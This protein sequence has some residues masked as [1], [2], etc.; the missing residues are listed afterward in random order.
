[1]QCVS[2][3]VNQNHLQLYY[4]KILIILKE[5]LTKTISNKYTAYICPVPNIKTIYNMK[6]VDDIVLIGHNSFVFDTPRLLRKEGREFSNQLQEMKVLFTD[7]L[8]IIKF[9]RSQP[10]NVL[11]SSPNNK[12][13]SVYKALFNC[14][15][16]AHDALV[17]VKALARIQFSLPL[18]AS[19]EI[20]VSRGKHLY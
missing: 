4:N 15:F 19:S 18:E 1:M 6:P 14:E 3:R 5:F 11:K 9:I 16:P 2:Q 12:L 20:I 7:S 13:G 17:H 8:P 10:N